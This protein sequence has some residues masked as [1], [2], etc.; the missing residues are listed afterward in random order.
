MKTLSQPRVFCLQCEFRQLLSFF[1]SSLANLYQFAFR[2]GIINCRCVRRV[3]WLSGLA[4]ILFL[5]GEIV[6]SI[7]D[8]LGSFLFGLDVSMFAPRERTVQSPGMPFQVQQPRNT[9]A[10]RTAVATV[11]FARAFRPTPQNLTAIG[12]DLSKIDDLDHRTR[13]VELE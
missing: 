10:T 8:C 6:S 11:V 9:A 1:F 5:P 4:V 12:S 2:L 7:G 3:W 13:W